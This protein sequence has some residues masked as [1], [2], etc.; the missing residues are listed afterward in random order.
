VNTSPSVTQK[1]AMPVPLKIAAL[2]LCG[3]VIAE[4]TFEMLYNEVHCVNVKEFVGENVFLSDR[5]QLLNIIAKGGQSSFVIFSII[6]SS[7]PYSLAIEHS[8][9]PSYYTQGYMPYIRKSAL[10]NFF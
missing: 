6:E 10:S 2:S 8:L 4:E 1:A 9:P 5:P 7:A 3:S